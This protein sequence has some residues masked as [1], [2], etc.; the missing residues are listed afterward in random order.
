M[1][2]TGDIAAVEGNQNTSIAFKNCA[3]FRRCVTHTNDEQVETAEHLD[4]ILPMYNLL[5]YSDNCADSYEQN[6]TN[7]GNANNVTTARFII[8]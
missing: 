1:L 2:L 4:I 7:T 3:P 6:M 5:E 8:S